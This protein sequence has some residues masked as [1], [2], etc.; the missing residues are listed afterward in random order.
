M[1]ALAGIRRTDHRL[2]EPAALGEVVLS[3]S[4][5]TL[6]RGGRQIL[7]GIDI[8]VRAG[9]VVAVVGPNGAGKSTLLGVLSGDD[10]PDA[11]SVGI[12]GGS[13]SEWTVTEL[14][15]RRAVLPQHVAVAFPFT[16][17]EIVRMGRAMWANTPQ[18][19]HDDAAIARAL[20]D[21][22]CA[23][24]ATR[25]FPSL[26]GGE[27]ARVAVAR[28]L[29]QEAG[30]LLMD[31]PTAALDLRHQ[32]LVLG[33][34][35]RRAENGAGVLVVVHDLT[36]AGAYADRVVLLSDGRVVADDRPGAVFT[37]AALEPVYGTDIAVMTHPVTGTPVVVTGASA[38]TPPGAVNA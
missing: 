4:D 37:P 29:A 34:A 11:G 15:W 3:G 36:L 30:V 19:D 1:S 12:G 25:K 13:I 24:L 23:H 14:A 5:V 22:E 28:V 16:A 38:T 33:A 9:E 35:R 27:R 7:R 32:D 20:A 31:E 10:T 17:I 21:A 18:E 8:Q 6:S 2:P 26:S